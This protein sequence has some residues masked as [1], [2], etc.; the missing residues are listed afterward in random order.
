MAAAV[1]A[2]AL[3]LLYLFVSY[4]LDSANTPR[5]KVETAAFIFVACGFALTL[6]RTPQSQRESSRLAALPPWTWAL[7]CGVAIALYW[8]ALSVGFLSDDFVLVKRAAD[9]NI[10]AVSPIFFRPLP[11]LIWGVLL[12]TGAGASTLHLLNLILHGT[13]AYLGARIVERWVPDS[14][15]A[16]VGGLLVLTAPLNIEAVVWCSG[17]FDLLATTLIL[18]CI[19]TA[20]QYDDHPRLAKR[21]LFV[22]VGVAALASKE[23]AAIA[24][25]LVLVD[26][27][28]RKAMSRRLLVD[29]FILIGI[30]GAFG[31][32]RLAS[33]S[34]YATPF[35]KYEMQS[36]LFG[37]FG[38][39]ATPWHVDVARSRPWLPIAGV[40][41]LI[42]LLTVFFVDAATNERRRLAVAASL[43]VLLPIVPV[44]ATFFVAPDLQQSRYLYLSVI[45]WAA[46]VAVVASA[47]S[48]RNYLK[49][50]QRVAVGGLLAIATY[51][52]RLHLQPWS[53]AAAL[54][55]RI[56]TAALEP[57]IERCPV[58]TVG[59]LPD[60]VR[61]AYVF[62]NGPAEAFARDLQLTAVIDNNA[63]GECAFRWDAAR[64]SFVR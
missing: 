32:W 12:K 18:V 24:A 40:L 33:V 11:L 61:G 49:V 21:L 27:Y 17:I 29:A 62:R 3:R 4:I 6:I 1:L 15:W 41:L 7:F 54:R 22:G 57:E 48:E 28:V 56:E 23:T 52:V 53:E 14:M 30:V 19:L 16:F 34:G 45:G 13:N 2:A 44:W 59:N 35:G 51:G 55:D 43:W 10:G 37:S 38:S 20:R 64:L 58:V 5:F 42:Y 46:L 9:W 60:S 26:A 8:P 50:L 63:V 47:G 25:P 39:L 36:L 31:V